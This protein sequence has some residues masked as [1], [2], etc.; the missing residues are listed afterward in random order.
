MIFPVDRLDIRQHLDPPC[1]VLPCK[2][3]IHQQDFRL[4][5]NCPAESD[6]LFVR[7][8]E[9]TDLSVQKI[10]KPEKLCGRLNPAVDHRARQ[11]TEP[12]PERDIVIGIEMPVERLI[13]ECHGETPV[14]GQDV[15]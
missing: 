8:G 13:L 10:C 2:I 9:G 12:E 4:A 5:D 11:I 6:P 1:I 15:V 14:A 7:I 3:L